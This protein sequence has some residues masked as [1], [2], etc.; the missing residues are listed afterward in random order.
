MILMIGVNFNYVHNQFSWFKGNA[1]VVYVMELL[2][3]TH[4]GKAPFKAIE[5]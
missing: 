2:I 4:V 1:I 3:K 5:R